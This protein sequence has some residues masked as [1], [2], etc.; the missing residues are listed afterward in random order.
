MQSKKTEIQFIPIVSFGIKK[1]MFQKILFLF[2]FFFSASLAMAQVNN[3]SALQQQ[4]ENLKSE[5]AKT[6]KLFTA[7][8]KTARVNIGQL[9][10]INKKVNLQ[11]NIMSSIHKEIRKLSDNIYLSQLEI[12][13][14]KRVLDTLK[15]EY[16]VSMVYAYKNSSNYT[17]LNF[18]FSS[19]SFN[20]AIKR[21]AYLKSYRSYREQQAVNILKTQAMLEQKV[22]ELTRS[23]ERKKD[24]LDEQGVEM[25]KLEK[26]KSEQADI[27]RKLKGKQKE[28]AAQI[29]AKKK[30]DSKL[31]NAIAAMIKR[32]IALAKA[33][34]ERKEKERLAALKKKEEERRKLEAS[35][36]GSGA[37]SESA[38]E[39]T[40]PFSPPSNS[41]LVTTEA[42][43]KLNESFEANKGKLPW[44]V[45]GYIV[46]HYGTNKLPGDIEFI[47]YGASI[48]TKI[49]QDVKA[50]FDGEVTLVSFIADN[51]AVYIRHGQYFTVYSNLS[52]VKVSKG[53]QVHTGQ[54]IGRAGESEEGDIGLVEFILMKETDYIDPEIWLK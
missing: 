36:G 44:P 28:L 12:N 7:T 9:A 25:N 27:V 18:I 43:V 4:R 54:L 3:K 50:V 31:R 49:G 33:E 21:I 2:I 20:D 15:Q 51:Q 17:F 53:D 5:I 48:G 24:V 6:Q 37:G 45:N 13:R 22:K 26:Q 40:K 29:R 41:V 39:E 34:K 38:T 42:E 23:K 46:Y 16:A 32:E 35:A 14:I 30:Q 52:S 10:L 11:E 47:N 19:E 8:K 1:I